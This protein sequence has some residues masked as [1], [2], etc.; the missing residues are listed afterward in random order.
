MQME[1]NGQSYC[2]FGSSFSDGASVGLEAQAPAI[3]EGSA[4]PFK[5]LKNET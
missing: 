5:M 1:K 3:P 2:S 4:G